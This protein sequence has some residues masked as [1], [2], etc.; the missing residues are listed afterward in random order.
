MNE[1]GK[2]TLTTFL[3]PGEQMQ[4]KHRLGVAY[5]ERSLGLE[6]TGLSLPFY[7]F[8]SLVG[9]LGVVV[10][11]NKSRDIIKPGCVFSPF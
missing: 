5:R 6:I 7:Y 2:V 1:Y 9:G 3:F 11:L 4:I 8:G 10:F